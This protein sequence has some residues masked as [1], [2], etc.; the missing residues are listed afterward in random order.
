VP[1]AKTDFYFFF[2]RERV[3]AS[4]FAVFLAALFMAFLSRGA[5]TNATKWHKDESTASRSSSRSSSRSKGSARKEPSEK[6]KG[7]AKPPAKPPAK[8]RTKG[9]AKPSAKPPA[10]PPAKARPITAASV[11]QTK[12]VKACRKPADKGKPRP[13]YHLHKAA[14]RRAKDFVRPTEGALAGGLLAVAHHAPSMPPP[15]LPRRQQGGAH[16]SASAAIA[17]KPGVLATFALSAT[18]SE[19]PWSLTRVMTRGRR[20]TLTSSGR[21]RAAQRVNTLPP[22]PPLYGNYKA[23]RE[24]TDYMR[25]Y[26]VKAPLRLLLSGPS[27][28][29]K[30]WLARLVAARWVHQTSVRHVLLTENFQALIDQKVEL[31]CEAQLLVV[32]DVDELSDR[33][34][35]PLA[36]LLAPKSTCKAQFLLTAQNAFEGQHLKFLRKLPSKRLYP[37]DRLPAL[38]KFVQSLRLPHAIP[39]LALSQLCMACKGDL[40]RLTI[41]ATN[42]RSGAAATNKADRDTDLWAET[43]AFLS[44]RHSVPVGEMPALIAYGNLMDVL[45]DVGDI[46]T[47]TERYSDA[48]FMEYGWSRADHLRSLEGVAVARPASGNVKIIFPHDLLKSLQ[49]PSGLRLLARMELFFMQWGYTSRSSTLQAKVEDY[50]SF[51]TLYRPSLPDAE[52]HRILSLCEEP[53]T[54]LRDVQMVLFPFFAPA[55]GNDRW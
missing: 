2:F 36:K 5:F 22:L 19:D 39:S 20:G 34:L 26:H 11:R 30:S 52:V 23:I 24:V 38:R 9:R 37:C 7:R 43:R 12:P 48:A 47:V 41:D 28:C 8:S 33:Y 13:L 53:V 18:S 44:N 27:G 54:F 42:Y 51:W 21:A 50:A 45:D 17:T 25:P 55:A 49:R 35:A 29:G 3:H 1:A 40:Q 31:P 46:A 4:F 14:A 15:S 32:L 10:K 16:R 6:K